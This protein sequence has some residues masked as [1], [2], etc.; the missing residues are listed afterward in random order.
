VSLAHSTVSGIVDRL[1]SKGLVQ[2]R[3]DPAD[4]RTSRVYPTKTVRQFLEEK[5]PLLSRGPLSSALSRTDPGER[6]R[7]E[8][9]LRRLRELLEQS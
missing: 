5:L 4:A 6:D 1:E 3:T 9:A 7:L 2:R 8:H